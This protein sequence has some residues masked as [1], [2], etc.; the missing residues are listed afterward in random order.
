MQ[1]S[2]NLVTVASRPQISLHFISFEIPSE[3]WIYF[4]SGCLN[5]NDEVIF[6]PGKIRKEVGI[7]DNQ[8]PVF[9]FTPRGEVYITVGVKLA[10]RNE[11]CP[12]GVKL[13]P[14]V[15][16]RPLYAPPH[17]YICT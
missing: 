8:R 16:G 17:F 5:V 14:R 1:I 7:Y 6:C 15:V 9:K 2:L 10:P 3:L 4:S 12:L 13:A 11:L